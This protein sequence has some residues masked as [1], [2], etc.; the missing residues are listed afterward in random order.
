MGGQKAADLIGVLMSVS[1]SI[2]KKALGLHLLTWTALVIC[3]A[4]ALTIGVGR[5]FSTS[6]LALTIL[7]ALL[8]AALVEAALRLFPFKSP[9][10]TQNE[11]EAG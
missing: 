8:S 9:E 1:A 5:G 2:R 10:R 6:I 4:Y 11:A 7:W 3:A